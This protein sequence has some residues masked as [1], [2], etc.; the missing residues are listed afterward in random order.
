MLSGVA[1]LP[2]G[3]LFAL[4]GGKELK[5]L[6]NSPGESDE[7]SLLHHFTSEFYPMTAQHMPI[8]PLTPGELPQAMKENLN[9]LKG[10]PGAVSVE[11]VQ[12]GDEA[13]HRAR[14]QVEDD[15]GGSDAA[16]DEEGRA[17]G[18]ETVSEGQ[19][20]DLEP[21]DEDNISDEE[22]FRRLIRGT[23]SPVFFPYWSPPSA[24]PLVLAHDDSAQEGPPT[25]IY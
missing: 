6:L 8:T 4:D 25:R 16:L 9:R 3:L 2:P 17:I 21:A 15:D 24:R 19:Q 10:Y 23:P 22:R 13:R 11:A 20:G 7:P 18:S 1:S 5:D 12:V 14:A